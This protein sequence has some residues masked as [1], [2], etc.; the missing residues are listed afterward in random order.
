[1]FEVAKHEFLKWLNK[2]KQENDLSLFDVSILNIILN[3]FEIVASKGTAG[4]SRANYIVGRISRNNFTPDNDPLNVVNTAETETS[5]VQRLQNI[6]IKSFRGFSSPLSFNFSK[7]YTSFYGVNGSGKSSLCEALEYSILGTVQE[8]TTRR[9]PLE[10]YLRNKK[11]NAFEKPVLKATNNNREE[12]F[13]CDLDA[14]KFSFVEKNR[15]D[16]FSHIGATTPSEKSERLAM[17][18]G[19]SEFTNFVKGFTDSL[20]NKII[21]DNTK[22]NDLK[23]KENAEKQDVKTVSTALKKID[24]LKKDIKNKILEIR[25][26]KLQNM[27][28]AINYLQSS[29][30]NGKIKELER[31]LEKNKKL[32]YNLD[33]FT[34]ISTA[35]TKL[36]DDFNN[37]CSSEN[38]LIS[39]AVDVNMAAIYE[40]VDKLTN[41]VDHSI[42]P[43]C[44]TPISE[45]TVNPFENA[46]EELAKLK[47]FTDLK[48]SVEKYQ[49]SLLN[50]VKSLNIL[51]EKNVN[52]LNVLEYKP[53]ELILPIPNNAVEFSNQNVKNV[54]VKTIEKIRNIELNAKI[55]KEKIEE[56]ND[57]SDKYNSDNEYINEILRLRELYRKLIEL[58]GSLKTSKDGIV[59]KVNS[60][61]NFKCLK[62]SLKKE[63]VVE[64]ETNLKK[65]EFKNAYKKIVDSLNEYQKELPSKIAKNLSEKVKEYYNVMNQG[66]A[67]YE[68]VDDLKMPVSS[69]DCISIKFKDGVEENALQILSEGH[70]KLLGLAVLLAKANDTKQNFIILDDIVNAIDDDHRSGVASLLFEHEDF[71]KVQIILTCHSESFI[72]RIEDCIPREERESKITRYVFITPVV[73]AIRGVVVDYA[74]PKEPLELAKKDLAQNDFKDAAQKCRQ[75]AESLINKLW[76]KI[77]NTYKIQISVGLSS[78]KSIPELSAVTDGIIKQMKSFEKDAGPVLTD[79]QKLKSDYQ[80]FLLN[81]GT[82]Y[83]D[84]QFQLELNDVKQ[85][86]DLLVEFETHINELKIKTLVPLELNE[87]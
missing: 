32:I 79:L 17:L 25:N 61:K 86:Y 85:L 16:S 66:D 12:N 63:V 15:I 52:L 10:E 62:E 83:E 3:N 58:K 59:N 23:E 19:L 43:V 60:L 24:E 68:M 49:N 14:Y 34:E 2:Y 69:N 8:A 5:K 42:C 20:E 56:I 38:L 64:N 28:D 6:E 76:K 37:L 74:N 21:P 41:D 44:K 53:S 35:Y 47:T 54:F 4:G 9:I 73:E 78:P 18:F 75:A 36:A 50:S 13:L 80:W 45:T 33:F 26:P 70:V 71:K 40:A 82:H 1:M 81:K 29:D 57:L 48:I 46:K 39:L 51:I 27:N 22:L 87:R 11:N 30:G 84:D 65:Q 67:D 77:S 55:D 31:L 72:K 7:Q